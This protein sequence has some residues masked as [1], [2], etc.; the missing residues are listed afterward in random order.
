MHKRESERGNDGEHRLKPYEV[1]ADWLKEGGQEDD[2]IKMMIS[3]LRLT[4]W[5]SGSHLK[6]RKTAGH[7]GKQA[8]E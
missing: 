7:P 8:D 1:E 2:W 5:E 6:N 3:V 4:M